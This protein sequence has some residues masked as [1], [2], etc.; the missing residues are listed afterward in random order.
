MS[1]RRVAR[2]LA[3]EAVADGEPLRWFEQL[4]AAADADEAAGPWADLVVNP[5]LASWSLF[6]PATMRRALVVGC[7]YGDDAEWLASRGCDVTAFDV[8]GSAIRACRERFPGSAV[9]YEVADILAPPAR[10]TTE[11]FDLVVEIS[12]VQVFA[13]GSAERAAV[14]RALAPVTGGTLLVIARARDAGGDEGSMPWPLSADELEPLRD[15]GLRE[16]A[17]DDLVDDED[18]PVRRF[19]ATYERPAR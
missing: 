6:D 3:H 12:T 14:V 2:R 5:Q 19:R 8:S 13:P 15:L 17:F 4:Y 18:P 10:W 7:G 1:E 16:V 9:G 11:P